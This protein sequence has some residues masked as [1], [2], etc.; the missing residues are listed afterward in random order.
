MV[1]ALDNHA[2]VVSVVVVDEQSQQLYGVI[3][4]F[5]C[6]SSSFFWGAVFEKPLTKVM[7]KKMQFMMP[8]AKLALSIAHVLLMC[9]DQ[10]LSLWRP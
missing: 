6:P 8:K 1:L 7:K 2:I 4:V 3:S 10:G 9:S 5:P